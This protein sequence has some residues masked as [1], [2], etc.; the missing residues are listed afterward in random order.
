VLEWAGNGLASSDARTACS[1]SRFYGTFFAG[2]AAN[3]GAI[4][5]LAIDDPDLRLR[6]TAEA[7]VLGL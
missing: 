7:V 6:M 5:A 4:A 1:R 2:A 3:T